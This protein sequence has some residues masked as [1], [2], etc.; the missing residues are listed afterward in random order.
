MVFQSIHSQAEGAKGRLKLRLV[1]C[2]ALFN[3]SQAGPLGAQSVQLADDQ[4]TLVKR[5]LE[6]IDQLEK[7]VGDLEAEKTSQSAASSPAPDRPAVPV[8]SAAVSPQAA[9]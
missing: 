6:R 5:L 9:T 4:T 8:A 7:R 1:L 2:L 3:I